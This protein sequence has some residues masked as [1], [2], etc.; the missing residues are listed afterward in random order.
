MRAVADGYTPVTINLPHAID[1]MLRYMRELIGD[2][3]DVIDD[4]AREDFFRGI[5]HGAIQQM[6]AK[7]PTAFERGAAERLLAAYELLNRPTNPA[8]HKM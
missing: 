2:P 3:I 4:Q 1:P 5:M 7:C 8:A 6:A